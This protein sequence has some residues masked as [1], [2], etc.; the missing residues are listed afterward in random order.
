MPIQQARAMIATMGVMMGTRNDPV[1]T[2]ASF[3]EVHVLPGRSTVRKENSSRL[4]TR[5]AVQTDRAPD[6][7]IMIALP[8]R[9]GLY[10]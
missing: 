3:H 4:R 10:G 8:S 6:L 2:G 9:T 7:L 5:L 1:M